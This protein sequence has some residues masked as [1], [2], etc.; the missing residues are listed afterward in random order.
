MGGTS[1]IPVREGRLPFAGRELTVGVGELHVAPVDPATTYVHRGVGVKPELRPATRKD[2]RMPY[3]LSSHAPLRGALP[4]LLACLIALAAGL[5][6]SSSAQASP[7]PTLTL[8]LAKSSLTVV[9]SPPQSGGVNVVSTATGTKEASAIL[10][11]LKPGVSVGEVEAFLASKA[12]KD[13]NGASKYGS[14]VFDAEVTPGQTSEVQTYLAAGQYVALEAEGE[15]HPTLRATFTISPAA[16]PVMLPA[17]AATV[18]SIE[19][20]FRG[21]T[22]LHDGELVRFEN[23]GFLVH[24]DI[25]FP[26]KSHAAAEKVVKDL[27]T[28]HEKGLEKLAAGAPFAFAGPL[29]PGAYQQET[30]TAKPGW[31]VQ[32]CFMETQDGRPHTQLGMERIFKIA[33]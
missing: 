12:A 7:L 4:A 19:F 9:G 32:A 25:A 26:V 20:G 23:E 31:Y 1:Y 6:A 33:K 28:G 21:P 22:V 24:M 10:F 27:L 15:G 18:R 30:I 2:H 29:S 17:P 5:L 3:R 13:P 11:L 14:I 16:S 8:T